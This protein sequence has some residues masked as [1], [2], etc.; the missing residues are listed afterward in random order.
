MS[1]LNTLL[2]LLLLLLPE[3]PDAGGREEPAP[4]EEEQQEPPAGIV[5]IAIHKTKDGALVH[6]VLKGFPAARAGI[7]RNDII[8][9]VDAKALADLPMAEIQN[10]IRGQPGSTVILE[11]RKRGGKA[12]VLELRRQAQQ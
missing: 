6:Q 8:T 5:G 4:A 2:L 11:I 1:L 10:L 9:H 3:A 7:E 12:E